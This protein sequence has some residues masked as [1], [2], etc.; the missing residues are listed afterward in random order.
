MDP[1]N[2]LSMYKLIEL[3]LII[4]TMCEKSVVDNAFE[5]DTEFADPEFINDNVVVDPV[6]NSNLL[7]LSFPK[8]IIIRLLETCDGFTYVSKLNPFP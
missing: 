4:P 6:V 5:L 7:L 1:I 8:L 2:V 3:S